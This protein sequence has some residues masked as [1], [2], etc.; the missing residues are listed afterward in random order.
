MFFLLVE[1]C[2]RVVQKLLCQ[3]WLFGRWG[4]GEGTDLGTFCS[5]NNHKI[6]LEKPYKVAAEIRWL[7]IGFGLLRK[8]KKKM[9]RRRIPS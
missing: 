7:G 1:A 6:F 3:A 5:T 4:K 2:A 8:K 9:K